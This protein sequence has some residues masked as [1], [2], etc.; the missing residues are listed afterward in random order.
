MSVTSLGI[1]DLTLNKFTFVKSQI[2]FVD[3]KK[4]TNDEFLSE[5]LDRI[6][7]GENI[8]FPTKKTASAIR[9]LYIRVFHK[10]TY[11]L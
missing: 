1:K 7:K 8:T 11:L 6:M 2:Q 9:F 3:G 10:S 5:I 4:Y